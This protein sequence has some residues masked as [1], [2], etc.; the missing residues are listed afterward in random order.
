VAQ[1]HPVPELES[2]HDLRESPWLPVDDNL[3]DMAAALA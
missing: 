1:V 3:D 2:D